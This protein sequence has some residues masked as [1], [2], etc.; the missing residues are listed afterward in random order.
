M[1]KRTYRFAKGVFPYKNA[2]NVVLTHDQKL[3]SQKND[4]KSL[5][6][7]KSPRDLVKYLSNLKYKNLLLIGGQKT[8]TQFF[9][10]NLID[11]IFV[12]VS[13]C[14]F[15]NGK[16]IIKKSLVDCKL[17]IL[18]TKTK[19][20]LVEL[21]YQ[22]VKPVLTIRQFKA[23]EIPLIKKFLVKIFSEFG[24][25]IEPQY[26]SDL[27]D[28]VK[29]YNP[30]DNSI[31]YVVVDGNKIIGTAGIKNKGNGIA[32]I[33]K[34]FLAS[35]YRGRGL[36]NRLLTKIINFC[37]DKKYQKIVLITD[38]KLKV[39]HKLYEKHGFSVTKIIKDDIHMAKLL[40]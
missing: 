11:E 39:A 10:E 21:H 1:G 34:M 3:L 38:P 8:I 23:T 28:M 13:P 31:F 4:D 22:V 37:Q 14:I 35:D 32:E 6:L 24:W 30:A 36:G 16:N 25:K 20:G 33:N 15:G 2:L 17:K 12:T 7:N 29:F 5:F 18:N 9:Q 26:D 27:D 19:N 40:S